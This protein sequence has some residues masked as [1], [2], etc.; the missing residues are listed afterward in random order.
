MQ[1]KKRQPDAGVIAR[2]QQQPQRF[3]FSQAV[4]LLLQALRRQG[5]G[6]EQAFR[7][8]LRFDNSVSLSFAASEI[9][10]LA[11]E[12]KH[13][14]S[15]AEALALDAIEKIR[16]TPA[17]IGLLGA[18]GTLPLHDSERLAEQEHTERDASQHDLVDVF[19]NRMIGLFYETWGKYRVEHGLRV[20]G[21]DELLPMLIA[22]AGRG[23]TVAAHAPGHTG[24]AS[25]YYAGIL[26]SRPVAAMTIER[27]LREH[28][29]VPMRLEQFVGCRD[30]IP[31]NR[32][33]TFGAHPILLGRGAVLGTRLWR[34]DRRARLHIGPLDPVALP[35]FLPGGSARAQLAEM[36]ALFGVPMVMW[37]VNLLL[38]PPC[39]RR[40]TL[41]TRS[42]P[43]QLGWTSF[44]TSRDGETQ[45]AEVASLLLPAK[46][47][48]E[49]TSN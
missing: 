34:H 45:R 10:Q 42:V 16:L 3:T 48:H 20:R 15:G 29:A 40:L 6:Y 35:R 13:A 39:I 5:I 14:A 17:F 7:D 21:R 38:A 46:R 43:R 2:L 1:A 8:V 26:G 30:E 28:F 37:E 36:M 32:R 41:T 49:P 44:L 23:T 27:I 9:A 24:I 25:A 33:S 31:A 4:S 11:L 22:L 12:R 18:A 19:S 47:L